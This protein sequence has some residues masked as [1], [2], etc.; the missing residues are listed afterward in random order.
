MP[1]QE[2]ENILKEFEMGRLSL[3]PGDIVVLKHPDRLSIESRNNMG[4]AIKEVLIRSGISN[5]V[6]VL[7]AGLD[8]NVLVK[9]L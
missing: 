9:E 6:I 8:I 4:D 1:N 7:E 2:T 3:K 5:Q